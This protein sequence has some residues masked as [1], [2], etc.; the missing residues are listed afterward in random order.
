MSKKFSKKEDVKL[1]TYTPKDS[2]NNSQEE[3]DIKNTNT[4]ESTPDN[5]EIQAHSDT[6]KQT[7]DNAL[8]AELVRDNFLRAVF[9]NW[10]Y[11]KNHVEKY[12]NYRLD[13]LQYIGMKRES[14]R[15][16]GGLVLNEN[17]IVNKTEYPDASFTTTWTMDLHYAQEKNARYFPGWE[18]MTWCTNDEDIWVD[19]YHVPYRCLYSKDIDNLFIGGRCMSVTHQALG[20]VRVQSTLGMAGEVIGMAAA[21]CKEHEAMP[22]DVYE[23]YLEELKAMMKKGAPLR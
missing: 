12:R 18:W 14:R 23:A 2:E 21:I 20:T 9:G 5:K 15:I 3:S 1:L 19:A 7:D 22:K 16:V 10:A 11:L 6:P 13:Y 4:A 17:D 8:E